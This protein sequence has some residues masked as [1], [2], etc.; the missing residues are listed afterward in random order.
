MET[1]LSSELVTETVSWS[2]TLWAVA[3]HPKGH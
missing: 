2:D 3:A 1:T